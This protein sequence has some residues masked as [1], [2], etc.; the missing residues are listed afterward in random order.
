MAKIF[1]ILIG[2]ILVNNY[3]FARFLGLCPFFGVTTKTETSI[4]MGLAVTFVVVVASI[5]TWIIQYQVLE[6]F[7]IEYL[8]TIVFILVIASLVQ[9]VEMALKK[10]SPS[11]YTAMGIFLPL[12]TTNCMVLGVAVLN[13]TEGY[14]LIETI[15]NSLGAALGFFLALMLLSTLR[16]QLEIHDVPKSLRGVPISY[17]ASGLMA[18]AFTGFAGITSALM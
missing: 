1:G 15:V 16:E 3:I 11:L 17:I 7:H 6:R 4:G 2:A 9:F 13:I 8:Q 18:L 14:N 10:L 12:I 5:V